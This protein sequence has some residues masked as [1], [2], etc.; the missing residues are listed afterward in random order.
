MRVVRIEDFSLDEI[1]SAA[2][3]RTNYEVVLIFSTKYEPGPAR[4]DRW[5]SWTE[6]KTRFFGFHLDL[7]PAAAAQILGGRVVFS[8]Q[9]QGQWVAVIEM[10]RS[11][12]QNAEVRS[13]DAKVELN[14]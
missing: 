12:M 3:F 9:R 7:P 4:W 5:R 11:E 2:D 8:E 10:E 6:W 14:F 13:Q 1:L